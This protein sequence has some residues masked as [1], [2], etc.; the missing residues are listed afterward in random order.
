[1][2]YGEYLRK[3]SQLR[4]NFIGFNNGQDASQQTLRQQARAHVT[5]VPVAVQTSF[6][7]IGGTVA[8]N[9]QATQQTNVPTDQ[10]CSSG[11][12]GVSLEYRNV[13]T[14]GNHIGK[15]QKAAVCS[16]SPSS[17]PYGI[18]IPCGLVLSTITNAPSNRSFCGNN[19][20]GIKF[21]DPS[22][23]IKVSGEREDLRKR[24]GQLN[25]NVS[26]LPPQPNGI[27]KNLQGLRSYRF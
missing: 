18:V 25:V 6:S 14:A 24:M 17:A 5:T 9:M 23:L 4:T 11:Y 15:L 20:A 16:D 2:N 1:M 26:G 7:K 21:S 22:E 13:D 12:I 8:N 10:S 19:D 27:P 3:K